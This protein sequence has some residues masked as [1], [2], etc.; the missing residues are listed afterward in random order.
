MGN[1]FIGFPV[2]K[3]KIA[4]MIIGEAAPKEHHTDHE[5][6]GDDEMNCTGLEGA[7]GTSLPFDDLLYATNFESI[8]GLWSEVNGGGA[9]NLDYH[10]VQLT[11]GGANDD[12]ARLK[13]YPTCTS[14]AM[15]W[16]NN[17]SFSTEVILSVDTPANTRIVIGTGDLG[18]GTGFGFII[19]NGRFKTWCQS[20]HWSSNFEIADWSGGSFWEKKRLKAHKTGA[21]EVKFYVDGSLVHTET[22]W[23]PSGDGAGTE[24][25]L[26]K[27]EVMN[28]A[29]G[30]SVNLYMSDYSLWQAA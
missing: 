22:E 16:N 21:S 26:L 12:L 13:R 10:Y 20:G 1:L 8:D 6:G 30:S 28:S 7:G 27:T 3:A 18:S 11:T 17:R 15:T 29:D 19:D 25:L 4:D 2:P 24:R 5:A 23:V 9:I 14:T